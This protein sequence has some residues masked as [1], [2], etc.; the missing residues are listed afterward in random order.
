M[1]DL[2]RTQAIINAI[3]VTSEILAKED[4]AVTPNEVAQAAKAAAESA[5]RNLPTK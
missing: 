2:T 5:V 1:S 4:R 3:Q